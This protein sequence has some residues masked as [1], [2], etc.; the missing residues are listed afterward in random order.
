[1][2]PR[3]SGNPAR[4]Q[5]IKQSRAAE[6]REKAEAL[7]R[8]L[9]RKERNRRIAL[10]SAV[11]AGVLVVAVVIV[12]VV[13][14]APKTSSYTAGGGTGAT[15]EG[16]ETFDNDAGHTTESVDYP[17]DPPAGGPHNPYWLNCG[18]YDQQV[19]NEN[20][21]HSLEHGA[22]WVT[23]SPDLSDEDLA[24]LKEWLPTSYVVLS[25]YEGLDSTIALSAWNAQL[26]LDSVEDERIGAFFEEYWRSDAVPEPGA[27]C[28]GAYEAPGKVG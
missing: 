26:K 1:M 23:Y 2:T 18:I 4:Q 28:T 12:S 14:T 6:R 10:W 9:R 3:S 13:V 27:S 8:E 5:S 20:A 17:Q 16:V 25:P 11:T 19:P 24:R 21:V 15:I 22:V 7:Q